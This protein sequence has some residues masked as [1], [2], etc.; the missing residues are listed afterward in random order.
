MPTLISSIDYSLVQQFSQNYEEIIGQ[1]ILDQANHHRSRRQIGGLVGITCRDSFQNCANAKNFCTL[2]AYKD[3]FREICK[4]TCGVCDPEAELAGDSV[5]KATEAATVESGSGVETP[6][7]LDNSNSTSPQ[8]AEP[9]PV[10]GEVC[11]DRL[12]D[13]SVIKVLCPSG[14]G[15][16]HYHCRK[17]CGLCDQEIQV[18]TTISPLMT[19]PGTELAIDGAEDQAGDPN[20]VDKLGERCKLWVPLCTQPDETKRK[21]FVL[22]CQKTCGLC[23]FNS[24]KDLNKPTLP[25][26]VYNK[27]TGDGEIQV[28]AD[29]KDNYPGCRAT[30]NL[31]CE[32]SEA[33]RV[34]CPLR[35]GVCQLAPEQ[36]NQEFD[37][38]KCKDMSTTVCATMKQYCQ[39]PGY[40]KNLQMMCPVT[41]GMDCFSKEDLANMIGKPAVV[42]T[43]MP[44]SA[45]GQ[46][47]GAPTSSP[48]VQQTA[49]S[50]QTAQLGASEKTCKDFNSNCKFMK[51]M[52]SS[53]PKIAD[54]CP[55]TCGKCE[56]EEGVNAVSASTDLGFTK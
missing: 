4:V 52:C 11:Q 29:C 27:E 50:Q 15:N 47:N 26:I 18:T 21:S 38:N 23:D 54:M 22:Q 2:D 30:T 53:R 7:A 25:P 17:T 12:A 48:A 16:A 5:L 43:V 36:Q 24:N 13:C 6:A 44:A 1:Q 10:E 42:N 56:G 8:T 39:D 45:A 55:V 20:C 49:N 33:V 32:T 51:T 37:E 28:T 40:T 34:N 19:T 14:A 41:C 35:C 46:V 31:M 3:R 9:V